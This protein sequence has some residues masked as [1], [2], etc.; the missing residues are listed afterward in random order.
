MNRDNSL[1]SAWRARTF[2]AAWVLYAG[3]YMCR[4]DIGAGEGHA[5]PSLAVTLAC[6][7]AMYAVGQLAGG[8]VLRQV[9][10]QVAAL[11]IGYDVLKA[12]HGKMLFELVHLYGA[13]TNING[14]EECGVTC[15]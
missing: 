10:G 8:V 15:H 14:A 3:Y 1:W 7:G 5:T 6:F 9:Q 13:A 2:T 4:K 11:D 12:G